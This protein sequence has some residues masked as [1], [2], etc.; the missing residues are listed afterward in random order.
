MFTKFLLETY[1]KL[2]NSQN[3]NVMDVYLLSIEIQL[4]YNMN[5]FCSNIIKIPI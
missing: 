3:Q 5:Y 1:L 4:Q 2:S